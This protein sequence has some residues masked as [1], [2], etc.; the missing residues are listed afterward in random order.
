MTII[1]S[2]TKAILLRR[3][4]REEKNFCGPTSAAMNEDKQIQSMIDFIDR[5]AREKAEELDQAAQEEYD[6]EKMRLVEAEKAKIRQDSE[7][8]KKQVEIDRRVSRANHSKQQRLRVMDERGKILDVVKEATRKK[9]LDLIKDAARYKALMAD[10]LRQSTLAIQCD[11][12]IC[13]RKA[14]EKLVE[15]LLRSTEAAYEKATGKQVSLS[16]GKPY[17]DDQEA[18]GG[19][20]V[21]TADSRIVCNNTLAYRTEHCFSEQLPTVR[22]MLFNEWAELQAKEE[23]S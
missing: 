21:R 16:V 5:E 12:E 13:C 3:N 2:T 11:A 17:L 14:D 9:I 23:S 8:K 6:V 15:S 19:V 10:L 7:R 20:V 4:Q 1:S 22:H 18:W